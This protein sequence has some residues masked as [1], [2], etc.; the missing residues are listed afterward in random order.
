MRVLHVITGLA[1]G[2][3]EQQ[4]RLILRHTD[5]CAAVVTLTSAG[6]VGRAIRAEG[7][8][9]HEIGMRGNTDLSAI[10]PLVRLIRTG[11]FDVVHTHLYRAV[12]YGRLAA[13]LARVRPVVATEHSLGDRFIE[14][15]HTSPA[16]RGL[17]LAAERLGDLTIAV[18]GTV[19]RRLRGWGV[20][21]SRIEVI[22]NGIEVPAHLFDPQRRAA[23]RELLGIAPDRVVVG[24]LGRLVPGKR[25][26]LVLRAACG[27]PGLVLLV[28][29]DGPQRPALQRLAAALGI[30]ARFT[31]ES[32]DVPGLMSAMDVLVSAS[33]E[34]TFG[35]AMIEGL[36]A[37]LPVLYAS[38]P[39]LD[40][41]PAGAAP[42]AARLPT[43]DPA[44][45]RRELTKI[46]ETGPQRLPAP[47]ILERFDIQRLTRQLDGV[48][49]RLQR[50]RRGERPG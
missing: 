28:V 1:A 7:T 6:A 13:R 34:E 37:G 26:E 49:T 21:E 30:P 29:G 47:A 42:G 43:G 50:G 20:R 2:G 15:R 9:V 18:S 19:A 35:M 36:A 23:V 41:L 33:P 38:C 17:Y 5:H 27:Q 11:R 25:T 16:I 46:A 10:P 39:A 12:L 4:L 3:A 45:I 31:G 8:E 32:L 44:A 40:D 48:Y 22:P 14:G 24:T